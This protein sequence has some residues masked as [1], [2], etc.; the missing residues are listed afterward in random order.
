MSIQ[1][2][3][4]FHMP[5]F[6]FISGYLSTN[7][8]PSKIPSRARRLLLPY[9]TYILI[10]PLFF[11]DSFHFKTYIQFILYPQTGLWFLWALFFI[12]C[13]FVI[14]TQMSQKLHTKEHIVILTISTASL[15]LI[16]MDCV[17]EKFAI[18]D[19]LRYFVFFSLGYL[20]HKNEKAIIEK[21]SSI[22]YWS[23]GCFC[24]LAPFCT[25][26]NADSIFYNTPI[27][28]HILPTLVRFITNI[29][30]C[31]GFFLLFKDLWTKKG[32]IYSL[33]TKLGEITL[34]I[35][36]FHFFVIPHCTKIWNHFLMPALSDAEI[37]SLYIDLMHALYIFV[38]LIIVTAISAFI[39]HIVSKNRY[40]SQLFLGH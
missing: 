16:A 5:L 11:N 37:S 8:A 36:F 27:V 13:I 40:T 24:M 7:I 20:F 32:L 2:I 28:G 23:L 35:Y 25:L 3:R 10:T 38:S 15:F 21:Y 6:M 22:V 19:I 29:C 9:L 39:V 33:F 31:V 1:L 14:G 12:D 34:G 26:T 4:A 17:G 30:G 18:H